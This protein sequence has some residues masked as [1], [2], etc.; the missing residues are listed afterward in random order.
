MRSE[1]VMRLGYG[2]VV[3]WVN[4]MDD[5]SLRAI[6]GPNMLTLRT[7]API[8]GEDLKTVATF[9]VAAGETVPFTLTYSPSPLPLPGAIDPHAAL[10]QSEAFWRGWA[11]RCRWVRGRML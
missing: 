2:A 6:A 1:L 5:G 7:M 9:S 11:E 10:Q 8:R 4:R 3:P